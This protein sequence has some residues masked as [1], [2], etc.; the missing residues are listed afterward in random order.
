MWF[1]D[2]VTMKWWN[3][4]WL[5]EAFATF[6]EMLACDAFRPEWERWT[7]FGLRARGRVRDRRARPAPGRSSSRSRSPADAEGMF[8]VLTYQKGGVGAAHARAVPR[9]RALPRGHPPLPAP[10]RLRQHRDRPTCGTPSRRPP[11]S[12]CARSWTPGSSR[13]ATRSS[14]PRLDGADVV[15]TQQRFAFGDTDDDTVVAGARPRAQRRRRRSGCSSRTAR[16]G[17]RSPTRRRRSSSTPAATASSASRTTT[18]CAPGSPAPRSPDSTRWSATTSSTTR[19]TRWWPAASRAAAFLSFVE[20]FGAERELA[21]WQA[22]VL[23]L[24]GL[25]RLLDD[26]DYPRFQARVADLVRAGRRRAGRPGRRRGRSARQA[27]RHACRARSPCW[28]TTPP[29]WRVS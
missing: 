4:I 14:T 15:L 17:C 2:L 25:G 28:A 7:T 9:R 1:G 11:A 22:I 24:R 27:P 18:S 13:A 19:G 26:D 3:G 12:R 21:V 5:N 8:D 16:R 6:M 20:G 10:P 23:G 29:P